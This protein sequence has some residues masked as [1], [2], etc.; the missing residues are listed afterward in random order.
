MRLI[1]CHIENFG[2]LSGTDITFD[3][4][5]NIIREDNGWGK[6]TLASFL[7]A[8]LYGLF[9]DSKRDDISCERK[10][11]K[12]WQG[13]A[14]GGSLSF[15]AD[16]KKYIVTRFFGNK[17]SDDFFEIRDMETNLESKAYSRNLGEELFGISSESFMN[18]IFINQ[19]DVSSVKNT[20]DINARI[21]NITDDAD[22]NRFQY[23]DNCIKDYLNAMSDR[24]KT[25]EIYK[26]KIRISKLKSVDA[27]LLDSELRMKSI[28]NQIDQGKTEITYLKQKI[29]NIRKKKAYAV[30]NAELLSNQKKYNDLLKDV[31][32][33]QAVVRS[34]RDFFPMDVPSG[35]IIEEWENAGSKMNTLRSVLTVTNQ[36]AADKKEYASLSDTF[37]S[38]MPD[39]SALAKISE[40][41]KRLSEYN[42]IINNNSMT[43]PEEK[44]LDQLIGTHVSAENST[45]EIEAMED[46]W[47]KRERAQYDNE[48][49]S[50]EAKNVNDNIPRRKSCLPILL[51]GMVFVFFAALIFNGIPSDLNYN[52]EI[53]FAL[54]TFGI[55]LFVFSIKRAIT[56]RANKADYIYDYS[57]EEKIEANEELIAEIDDE[58]KYYFSLHKKPFSEVGVWPV[59]KDLRKEISELE[60]LERKKKQA[61]DFD[62]IEKAEYITKSLEDFFSLYNVKDCSDYYEALSALKEKRL[63]FFSYKE[64]ADRY[65]KA[66]D[67]YI[68]IAS[69][70]EHSLAQYGFSSGKDVFDTLKAIKSAY[71]EYENAV[72]IYRY[73][74]E[75]LISFEETV[76]T[77]FSSC[78]EC[79]DLN[80]L[81]KNEL[82]L[83]EELETANEKL[84][85]CRRE[86]DN[87]SLEYENLCEEKESLVKLEQETN[88][89]IRKYETVKK[90]EEY[91][92]KAKE[93]LTARYMEPLL[94]GFS[95]YYEM[96]TDEEGTEYHL[97]SETHLTKTVYGIQRDVEAMSFGYRDLAGLCLRMAKA[98]AMFLQEKPALIMDDPFVNFDDSKI[99]LAKAFLEEVKEEY[100]ILY[101]T[102]SNQRI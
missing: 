3:K 77:D 56:N 78:R 54:G 42:R 73:V 99:K 28:L 29:D 102:C 81:E 96:L 51:L 19:S 32:E 24:R 79:E 52:T 7:K 67:E 100:Q 13:G 27:M 21:G 86:M 58:M 15:E 33:K 25:G 38:G 80:A 68:R 8:M 36:S 98:D 89:K 41:I 66:K 45:K 10:R 6:S 94:N 16:G 5:L 31:E 101:L 64:N 34:K 11:F 46:K 4:G 61:P 1:S 35:E 55:L 59:L 91:L 82:E 22:L 30:K 97:D 70:L 72:G 87:C 49:L 60:F 44:R 84:N 37:K 65:E 47:R 53:S 20:D 93:S 74:E 69:D 76:E 95:K 18:T 39:S 57:L 40:E 2:K 26:D 43:L 92:L 63:T 71:S 23:A 9:G 17:A 12:P 83:L 85:F 14:F 75:K 90:T 62:V 88:E 50:L 48:L